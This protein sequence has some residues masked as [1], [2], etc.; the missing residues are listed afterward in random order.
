MSAAEIAD[1]HRRDLEAQARY[2]VRFLT[3]WHDEQRGTGFCLID[4]PNKDAATRVH[5]ETHGIH[6]QDIIEVDLSA[7]QAFLG[8]IADPGVGAG[9]ESSIDSAFRTIM[10]TD[11]VGSTE[12]TARLGDRGSV[13]M[14]RAHDGLVRQALSDFNGREVKHLGDGIMASFDDVTSALNAALSI[15]QALARFREGSLEKLQVRIGLDAGEPVED[16]HDLFGATVQLAARLCAAAAPDTILVSRAIRDEAS[17]NFTIKALGTRQMKG[18]KDPMP[19][20]QLLA[21]SFQ[22]HDAS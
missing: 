15:S 14:V 12:M 3:Y 11:I 6:T 21:P 13:E 2:G 5:A 18:F 8:R 7:V 22:I 10:F 1:A 20:Y 9:S 4:A 16:S 19:I 17:A